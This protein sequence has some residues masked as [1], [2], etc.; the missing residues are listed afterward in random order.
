MKT[1]DDYDNHLQD[2][3][4]QS[5]RDYVAKNEI[6]ETYEYSDSGRVKI[7]TPE[8]Y[9]N[10]ALKA[11]TEAINRGM[12]KELLIEISLNSK[13]DEEKLVNYPSMFWKSNDGTRLLEEMS[14]NFVRKELTSLDN[15]E[16]LTKEDVKTSF[17]KLLNFAQ[18]L[19][20]KHEKLAVRLVESFES[21]LGSLFYHNIKTDK[22]SQ[23]R[24]QELHD[25]AV[26]E[27]IKAENLET[28]FNVFPDMTR[29]LYKIVDQVKTREEKAVN[30]ESRKTLKV[31]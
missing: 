11:Y 9:A 10:Q 20:F 22:I 28:M 25:S 27:T 26:K 6:N 16:E 2:F 13:T 24:A 12:A 8:L 17:E 19:S 7:T 4:A 23:T 15:K 5:F 30:N 18:Q 3:Y 31:N 21:N 1:V 14:T 29:A